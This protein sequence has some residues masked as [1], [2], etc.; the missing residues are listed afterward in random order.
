MPLTQNTPTCVE[1]LG[2]DI[3]FGIKDRGAHHLHILKPKSYTFVITGRRV[4]IPADLVKDVKK[5]YASDLQVSVTETV[6][7]EVHQAIEYYR[8]TGY[9]VGDLKCVEYNGD[10]FLVYTFAPRN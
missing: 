5:L 1:S 8:H 10:T 4:I 6:K 9:N 2:G 3:K 7:R